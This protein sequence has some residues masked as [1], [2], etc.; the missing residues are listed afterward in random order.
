MLVKALHNGTGR[1]RFTLPHVAVGLLVACGVLLDA[2]TAAGQTSL[3]RLAND[4][5]EVRFVADGRAGVCDV[6]TFT[7]D[8]STLLAVGEDKVIHRWAV[9]GNRLG[10]DR[11]I[12]W[13]TFRE[14]R[15]SIYALALSRDPARPLVAIG[16]NGK[17]NADVA[18]F[19]LRTGQLLGAVSPLTDAPGEYVAARQVVWSLAFHP[20]G[21]EL[22]IGDDAGNVWVCPLENGRP[23]TA[24]S[25]RVARS[26]QDETK[27]QYEL[28]V[29]WVGYL[30]DGRLAYARR[31]GVV[32]AVGKAVDQPTKLFDW[33][34]PVDK[35]VASGD[36]TR[37]AARPA[38]GIEGKQPE[39]R[40]ASLPNGGGERVVRLPSNQFPDRIALDRTGSQ[41]A[42]GSLE[43]KQ[44]PQ[45]RLIR[46]PY[47]TELP[48]HVAVIDVAANEPKV[49]ASLP[50]GHRPDH[51]A[52]H[53]DGKRLATADSLRHGTSLWEVAGGK[54]RELAYDGSNAAGLW[55][56]GMTKDG[57]YLSFKTARNPEPDHPNDRADPKA[58]WVTFDLAG[59]VRGWAAPHAPVPPDAK[60]GRNDEWAVAFQGRGKARNEYHWFVIEGGKREYPLPLNELQ[61]DRPRCYTFLP[62]G[63][64]EPPGSARLAVGHAWGVSVFDLSPG[65]APRRIRRLNGH[66]GYVTAVAPTHD[67]NGLVTCGRDGVIA[68]W[69]LADFPS[70][71]LMGANFV[72]KNGKVFVNAVDPGSPAHEAGLSSGDEVLN[73]KRGDSTEF[74]PRAKWM[75]YF[76]TPEPNREMLW[77]LNPVGRPPGNYGSRTMLLH[78]PA[79]RFLPLANREWVLY[80]YRQCY[81]DC[82]ANGDRYI[83]WLV[84]KD[85]ADKQPDV[86]GVDQF[87]KFLHRPDK[88]TDVVTR[89]QRES[90]RP[91]LPDLFPPRVALKVDLANPAANQ[92]VK[93]TVTVV[94]Q[95]RQDGKLNSVVRVELILNG[96]RR[97]G[98]DTLQGRKLAAGV[99]FNVEFTVR[100]ADLQSGENELCA[101]GIG[102]D[103]PGNDGSGLGKSNEVQVTAPVRAAQRRL[104]VL[105]AGIGDYKSM[106]PSGNM[107]L[108]GARKD[109]ERMRD[110]W[111]RVRRSGGYAVDATSTVRFL[112][113]QEVTKA[114]IKEEIK[115]VIQAAQSDDRFVLFLA[116]HGGPLPSEVEAVERSGNPG[117]AGWYFFIPQVSEKVA[118]TGK[119][120]ANNTPVAQQA[121]LKDTELADL[122]VTDMKCQPLVFLD[123]C[124]SGSAGAKV[125]QRAVQ[126]RNSSRSLHRNGYG[127][128][129]VAACSPNEKAWESPTGGG[130]FTTHVINALNPHLVSGVTARSGGLTVPEFFTVVKQ[131]VVRDAPQISGGFPQTPE[132][133]PDVKD[134]ARLV[135]LSRPGSEPKK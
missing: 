5:P 121:F 84:S 91:I 60:G 120:F 68:I 49:V 111:A 132:I 22:A 98:L 94:P 63:K 53:P 95:A 81:Y 30:K 58:P 122:L 47:A 32:Y 54:L 104:F 113:D 117:S 69:N 70:Q 40:I 31:D 79:A 14:Q 107:D 97:V 56:V 82:S 11:P 66:A 42:I 110:L 78:R 16:G 123:C 125:E 61:D 8:G 55:A 9:A 76:R 62:P 86:F 77:F 105:V 13:N 15:G 133:K 103:D 102:A 3:V 39:V 6:L 67:G 23:A 12:F 26:T 29:V 93:A 1:L 19:D 64:G 71:P 118:V 38:S 44:D 46:P 7:P 83:Q 115:A 36:G 108:P 74:V 10:E 130:I 37:L 96:H 129:V 112:Q 101:I 43:A 134:L 65:Q 41:L 48:G 50:V 87:R 57:R 59:E 35:V 25:K 89:L 4:E 75:E 18:I 106:V 88:V 34:M 92:D 90:A 28:R 109:A 131:G 21:R 51:L 126:V 20:Q 2:R 128:V 116:G 80:T 99:P 24:H 85:R 124:Y 33:G 135:I 72:E 100:A 114:R 45:G 119:D 17:L 52:F 127:P 73:F 27:L